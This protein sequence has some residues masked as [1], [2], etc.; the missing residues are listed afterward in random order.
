LSTLY[1]IISGYGYKGSE[2]GGSLAP[3]FQSFASAFAL[4]FWKAY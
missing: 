1:K 4:F 3:P 2:R